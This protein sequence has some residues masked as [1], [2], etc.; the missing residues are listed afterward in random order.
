MAI[1]AVARGSSPQS[2]ARVL[3]AVLEYLGGLPEDAA[4]FLDGG[5]AVGGL[6]EAQYGFR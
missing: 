5:K 4:G 3:G 6:G 1:M 2:T